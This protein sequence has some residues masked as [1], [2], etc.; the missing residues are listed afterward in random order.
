MSDKTARA[1]P[2][3]R[4]ALLKALEE[5]ETESASR[6]SLCQPGAAFALGLLA[7]AA[8][9]QPGCT[10]GD[11]TEALLNPADAPPARD[12]RY[13]TVRLEDS[14]QLHTAL[15][16]EPGTLE[17]HRLIARVRELEAAL[18]EI[19]H[20]DQDPGY[21]LQRR[22]RMALEGGKSGV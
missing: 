10:A 17:W 22:A 6:T 11:I 18:T 21:R 9:A 15:G 19:A 16:L 8:D 4:A 3:T 5:I 2:P 13:V 1:F 7:E 20:N 14:D 12:L